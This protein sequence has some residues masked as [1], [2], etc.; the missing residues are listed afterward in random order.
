MA[1]KVIDAI[2]SPGVIALGALV[3]WLSAIGLSVAAYTATPRV[4][5]LTER[6]VIAVLISAFLTLYALVAAN[7]EGGFVL[8][9]FEES[10]RFLRVG[11]LLLAGIGPVWLVLWATGNLGDGGR[12]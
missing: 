4:G 2:L 12:G 7:T 1:A 5:A 3:S 9:P 10:V 8:F 6:A 11:V